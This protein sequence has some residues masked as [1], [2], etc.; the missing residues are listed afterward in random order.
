MTDRVQRLDTPLDE[1]TGYGDSKN[2]LILVSNGKAKKIDLS[3]FM[4]LR[5]KV[6]DDKIS[7]IDIMEK[8]KF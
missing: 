3:D 1:I 4:E 5:L 8:F 7:V 6:H 2:Y